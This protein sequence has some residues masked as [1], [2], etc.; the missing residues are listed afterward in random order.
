MEGDDGGKEAPMKV[1]VDASDIR[2]HVMRQVSESLKLDG[3]NVECPRCSRRFRVR[4]GFNVC[5]HCRAGMNAD[6]KL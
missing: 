6:F 1:S 4:G 5:P 2:K 3:V